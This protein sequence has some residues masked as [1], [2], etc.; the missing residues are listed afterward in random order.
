VPE[1][2][3]RSFAAVGEGSA[4]QPGQPLPPPRIVFQ[5]IEE[6]DEAEGGG[7]APPPAAALTAALTA[8]EEAALVAEVGAAGERVRSL[9]ASGAGS[10]EVGGA[11]ATLL[12]LKARDWPRSSRD[13]PRVVQ[14]G[15]AARVA[16]ERVETDTPL[17]FGRPE[18]LP[19]RLIPAEAAAPRLRP[20]GTA[21]ARSRAERQARKEEEVEGR[22]GVRRSSGLGAT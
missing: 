8:A 2:G 17:L 14:I 6:A 7:E 1:G 19:E 3:G 4:L 22:Q 11:V 12:E 10:E 20:A 13:S 18:H 5:R 21:A 9:K 15:H 16:R